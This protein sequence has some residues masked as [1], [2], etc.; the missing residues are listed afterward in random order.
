MNHLNAIFLDQRNLNDWEFEFVCRL[1][2]TLR[3]TSKQIPIVEKILRKYRFDPNSK[4]EETVELVIS[5]QDYGMQVVPSS[6]LGCVITKIDYNKIL[7]S[8]KIPFKL[9]QNIK[10]FPTRLMGEDFS[11]MI[12]PV[13]PEIAPLL[14]E[15]LAVDKVEY[16]DDVVELLADFSQKSAPTIDFELDTGNDLFIHMVLEDHRI[17]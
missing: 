12:I 3:I 16:G 5:N 1:F 10:E 7:I 17:I 15:L 9:S 2:N 13:F 14:I 6:E 8:G 11:E 4:L